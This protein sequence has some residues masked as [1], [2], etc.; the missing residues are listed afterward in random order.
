MNDSGAARHAH[1]CFGNAARGRY[2]GPEN[3][4][5]QEPHRR[6]LPVKPGVSQHGLGGDLGG[7]WDC[8]GIQEGL[9]RL[10]GCLASGLVSKI[11]ISIIVH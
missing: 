10:G 8:E 4:R 9:W 2:Q 3:R 7:F 5:D 11:P 1:R 6:L